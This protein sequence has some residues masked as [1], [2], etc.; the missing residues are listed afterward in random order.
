MIP[1]NRPFKTARLCRILVGC[2]VLAGTCGIAL[3]AGPDLSAAYPNPLT[4][5]WTFSPGRTPD[6]P[7]YDF[8]AALRLRYVDF[9]NVLALGSEVD[10]HRRFFRIRTRLW[11]ERWFSPGWRF[12]IQLNNESRSYLQCESCR[13]KFD[14]VIVENLFFEFTNHGNNPMGL[15]I[16]RQ[17][18]FYGDGF[19][20]CDGTPLDGSRTA[21]TNGVLLTTAIPDWAFDIFAVWNRKKDEWLPRINNQYKPLLEY[22]EFVG[23]LYVRGFK[24]DQAPR[25][26][27]IDYYYIF[28]EEETSDRFA[29]INTFGARLEAGIGRARIT[30][31][32]A[33]QAG[34]APE[35]RFVLADTTLAGP[36]T[37]AAYGGEAQVTLKPLERFPASISGGY[38][39]LSGDDPFTRNK[40][41]GW[42]PLMGRWPKWS[43]LYIYTLAAE[44]AVQPMGQ[45]TAF[46]QNFKA[47]HLGVSITPYPGIDIEARHMWMWA[48]KSIPLDPNIDPLSLEG[49]MQPKHRGNLL[50]MKVTWRV[51]AGVPVSGHVLYERL[52]PGD[53]YGSDA[54]TADFF[55]V[56]LSTSL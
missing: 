11:G 4:R 53:Y 19:V 42:N 54:R 1:S 16:G 34:R 28:S 46:W 43:E 15:R 29:S 26:Y 41:E 25:P 6:A 27:T 55:R 35:S 38:V 51:P 56:E 21:Y 7:R 36:Q 31:E 52:D 13:S 8:G 45:G 22:D 32:A 18:L 47:P 20:I 24:P 3:S 9:N 14:E 33:Y 23:G 50:A 5:T 44:A 37:I 12:F 40:F 49:Q 30:A 48:D 17:D 10:P 39:H 2:L